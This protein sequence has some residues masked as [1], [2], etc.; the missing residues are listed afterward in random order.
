VKWN[1]LEISENVGEYLEALWIS[2]ESGQ[3]LARTSLIAQHLGVSPPS[4]VEMLKNLQERGYLTYEPRKGV[5][6]RGKGREIAGQIIRNHR[7]TEILMKETLY[8]NIDEDVACGLEHHMNEEFADAICTLLKHPR[9]CPHGNKV[10]HGK[11][12]S[13]SQ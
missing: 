6:L 2:E 4:V 10:P 13:S 3:P 7:L 1:R 9:E 5:K 12:C 8:I 11:C